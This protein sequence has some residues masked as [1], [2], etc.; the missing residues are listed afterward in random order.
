MLL[1]RAVSDSETGGISRPE[2]VKTPLETREW[3]SPSLSSGVFSQNQNTVRDTN[4]S[5]REYKPG[6][7]R[8]GMRSDEQHPGY[9]PLDVRMVHIVDQR[10]AALCLTFLKDRMAGTETPLYATLLE[11]G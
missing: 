4:S 5:G 1:F 7:I 11:Q 10:R 2:S 8:P 9:S 6:D 3:E